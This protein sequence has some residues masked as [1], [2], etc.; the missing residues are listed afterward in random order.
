MVTLLLHAKQPFQQAIAH[1]INTSSHFACFLSAMSNRAP[2]I[3]DEV[4]RLDAEILTLK[5]VL[6][7]SPYSETTEANFLFDGA[8][9]HSGPSAVASRQAR[10]PPGFLLVPRFYALHDRT[11]ALVQENA[12]LKSALDKLTC[13]VLEL[14][15]FKESSTKSA[16]DDATLPDPGT[17]PTE[18]PRTP[19]Y[20]Q[21]QKIQVRSSSQSKGTTKIPSITKVHVVP[22]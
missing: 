9:G 18:G 12:A 5:S 6:M 22:E 3:R 1:N 4:T 11:A 21:E 7:T 16:K 2:S 10:L 8:L 17:P 19:L 20:P 15:A 13:R 14:E